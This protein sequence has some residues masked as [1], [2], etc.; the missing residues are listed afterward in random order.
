ML[1][2]FRY[3]LTDIACIAFMFDGG[4]S[5]ASI[6]HETYPEPCFP[7]PQLYL[8]SH[9]LS[10]YLDLIIDQNDLPRIYSKDLSFV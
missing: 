7:A 8:L 1:V 9:T 2:A 10:L 4:K 3:D 5:P 6:N